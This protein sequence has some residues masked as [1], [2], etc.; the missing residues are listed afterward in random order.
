VLGQSMPE[1]ATP[2]VVASVIYKPSLPQSSGIEQARNVSET[3]PFR[4]GRGPQGIGRPAKPAT[5]SIC[6]GGDDAPV[7]STLRLPR[8]TSPRGV[9]RAHARLIDWMLAGLLDSL[10]ATRLSFI[11]GQILKALEVEQLA[12]AQSGCRWRIADQ[13]AIGV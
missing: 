7:V 6:R 8:T 2:P 11:F 4:K 13:A 12:R 3:L 1:H 10:V 9:R 5:L